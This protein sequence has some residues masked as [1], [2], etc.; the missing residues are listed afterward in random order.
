MEIM[1]KQK[2]FTL[3]EL[4]V[5]IFVVAILGTTATMGLAS[6]FSKDSSDISRELVSK[7]KYLYD[8]AALTSSYIRIEFDF[9]KNEYTVSASKDRVLLFGQKRDVSSGKLQVSDEEKKRNELIE[10]EEKIA[11]EAFALFTPPEDEDALGIISDHSMKRYKAARFDKIM[12][13]EDLNFTVTLPE[14][15]K[16]AGVYTEY[17]EDYVTSGKAEI[18][19][20]PN[21]Y[22][23]RSVII[24]HDTDS[25]EYKSI[26][27][28]PYSGYSEVRNDYYKLSD[29]K[30]EV[31]DDE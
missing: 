25:E 2:A 3:I 24:I 20:F 1:I 17:Y 28:E 10:E 15:I 23:Q 22:V 6:A 31:E 27:V 19:I 7:I 16:F 30:E 29:E 26:L 11:N 13:D 21:N 4:M 12:A 8:R 18:F 9:E 14:G 5:V